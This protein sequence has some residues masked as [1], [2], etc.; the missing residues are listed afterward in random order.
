MTQHNR[1]CKVLRGR[2]KCP[3]C[4]KGYMMEWAY[5]NHIKHCIDEKTK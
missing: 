4:Q 3:E 5:K 1:N 2:Y